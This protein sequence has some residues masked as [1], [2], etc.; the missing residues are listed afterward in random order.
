M[1]GWL[2]VV[3]LTEIECLQGLFIIAL[4]W[5]LN[6]RFIVNQSLSLL[7]HKSSVVHRLIMHLE[8]K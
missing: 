1:D 8:R 7:G 2:F 4:V 5:K 6:V 3:P